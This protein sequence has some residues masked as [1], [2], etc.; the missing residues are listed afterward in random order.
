MMHFACAIVGLMCT[1]K[2]RR[3]G[4][5]KNIDIMRL[6][7]QGGI[8]RQTDSTESPN[9]FTSRPSAL[10]VYASCSSLP[11]LTCLAGSLS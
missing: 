5:D 4:R 10:P 9:F 8:A 11:N 2:F 3:A 1:I 6:R 7:S